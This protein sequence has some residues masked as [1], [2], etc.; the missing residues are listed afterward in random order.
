MKILLRLLMF[1]PSVLYFVWLIS[2]SWVMSVIYIL[3]FMVPYEQRYLI[4]RFWG[5][6]SVLGLTLFCCLR[7]KVIGRENLTK[8]PVIVFSKHQSSFEILVLMSS[9][10]PTSWV[11]K[12]EILRL[13]IF[14]WAF[15]MSKPICL[16]RK[17]GISAVEQLNKQGQQALDEGRNVLI[18]PEGTRK[19][20]GSPPKYRIGGAL[21]AEKTGYPILPVAHNAGEFWPRLSF[22]KWPGKA[23]M[24]FGP[25]IET[26]GKKAA[27]INQE[28]QDWIEGKM[29]EISD[30]LRWNR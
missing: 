9:L 3:A 1:I 19:A 18:F 24:I 29:A 11:A 20:P 6:M 12:R 28:A 5:Y 4:A 2:V 27:E 21:L 30:P 16:D 23:T 22:F 7:C 8:N 17:A 10:G 15:G 25:L 14:G 13:P 26:K